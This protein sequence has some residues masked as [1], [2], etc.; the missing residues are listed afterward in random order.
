[1]ACCLVQLTTRVKLY[2]YMYIQCSLMVVYMNMYICKS[3]IHVSV[4]K[5]FLYYRNF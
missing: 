2:I 4:M 3:T 5:D 1:M